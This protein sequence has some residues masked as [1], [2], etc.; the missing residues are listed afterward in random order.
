MNTMGKRNITFFVAAP[1]IILVI[2]AISRIYFAWH[3]NLLP[4]HVS[5][6]W[7]SLAHDLSQGIFYRPLYSHDS[8]YGGTRF[9]PLFFVIYSLMSRIT[10]DYLSAGYL[11][12]III[13]MGISSV[14]FFMLRKNRNITTVLLL[15]SCLF[16]SVNLHVALE[17]IR[18]DLT[19]VFFS[20]S[21]LSFAMKCED[22]KNNSSLIFAS[23]FFILAFF[24][25]LTSVHGF[26]AVTIWLLVRRQWK[27]AMLFSLIFGIA[28]AVGL[29]IIHYFSNGNFIQNVLFSAS[30]GASLIGILRAP[31]WFVKVM[32]LTD[33]P[34]LFLLVLAGT[35]FIYF[36][37]ESWKSL[38]GIYLIMTL[39]V[40]VTI[41]G[42]PGTWGNH[43]LD[44]H[45]A[46]IV[47]IG[48]IVHEKGKELV[49][50]V[51][52]QLL[53]IIGISLQPLAG[54]LKW[55]R[56]K[57]LG[58]INN[59]EVI[60]LKAKHGKGDILSEN[61]LI[62]LVLGEPVYVQDAFML[63]QFAK[64]NRAQAEP[65]LARIRNKDF[66]ILFMMKDIRANREWYSDSHFG[67]LITGEILNNYSLEGPCG[68]YFI[69]RPKI[70][71]P[72]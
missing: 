9:M 47:F 43:L 68:L 57:M 66:R 70:R 36:I 35:L 14:L 26:A 23:L 60:Q 2:I 20:L 6:A 37:K 42:S 64:H 44:L 12:N 58:R 54:G 30:G 8:G 48:I 29:G 16:I 56:E 24:T 53:L 1:L 69:Y 33:I 39:G 52:L 62:P 40:T 10:G 51:F 46:V 38:A 31:L 22:R 15:V 65:L 5:G 61:P 59:I 17:D 55:T 72:K 27:S 25:K 41:F 7:T 13:I 49:Y 45:I 11:L 71:K 4:E 19:A 63:R 18:G 3:G 34:V 67:D 28:A 21:G 50:F 32:L